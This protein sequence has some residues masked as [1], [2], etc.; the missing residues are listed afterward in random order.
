MPTDFMYLYGEAQQKQNSKIW[1]F[2]FFIKFYCS[3]W[4]NDHLDGLLMDHKIILLFYF[5]KGSKV[6]KFAYLEGIFNTWN[7]KT[8]QMSKIQWVQHITVSSILLCPTHYCVKQNNVSTL[9][10]NMQVFNFPLL[11]SYHAL[12]C[13]LVTLF[14]CIIWWYQ[15]GFIIKKSVFL[16]FLVF[17]FFN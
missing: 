7:S 10:F 17:C 15:F 6:W 2:L 13:L 11:Q 1:T 14:C 16:G 8:R 4:Q 12:V 5:E 9:A 3:F